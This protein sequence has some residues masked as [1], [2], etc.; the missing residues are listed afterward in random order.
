MDAKASSAR[1]SHGDQA[2]RPMTFAAQVRS[3]GRARPLEKTRIF[4]GPV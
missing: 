2:M 1:A 4:G 3:A